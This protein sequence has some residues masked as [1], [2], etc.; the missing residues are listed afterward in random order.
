[1]KNPLQRRDGESVEERREGFWTAVAERSGD[2][3]L[4][5]TPVLQTLK[6]LSACESGLARRFPPQSINAAGSFVPF[7]LCVLCVSAFIPVF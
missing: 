3:A 6:C 5:R 2:T 7:S 1:M 4:G